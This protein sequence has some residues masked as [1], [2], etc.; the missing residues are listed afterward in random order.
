MSKT[1]LALITGASRGIGMA[2]AAYL[3]RAGFEIIGTATGPTGIQAIEDA[4]AATGRLRAALQ[5]DVS[6]ADS[7]ARFFADL[8]Q[9]ELNP[10]VLVNNAGVT[11]DNLLLR[12]KDDEWETVISANLNAIFRLTRGCLKTMVKARY[13]RI[14]NV[15]S[16]VGVSGNAGQSNYAAAKAGVIG[17]TKSLAQEVASRGITVNAVAPGFIDTDMTGKLT[18]QQKEGALAQ[19][20]TKRMG[21][22][23]EIAAAIGF[24]AS[25]EAAYIT[26]ETI[27][28][29]GGMY[30]V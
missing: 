6:N 17:F 7:I 8:A 15:T 2:T 11:R 23:D 1:Q 19:I 13:G 30:M 3:A 16:V 20:P 9:A 4:L 14:I 26:G 12:M 29:N 24:L 21:H 18:D 5:L 28:V 25:S 10:T 22:P 27:H